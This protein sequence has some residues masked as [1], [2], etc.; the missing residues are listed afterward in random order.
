MP[1]KLSKEKRVKFEI[2]KQAVLEYVDK[3]LVSVRCPDCNE[4]LIV[5]H[6]EAV[7]TYWVTCPNQCLVFNVSGFEPAD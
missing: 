2:A 3:Q 4:P 7:S 5:T 6:V 1:E